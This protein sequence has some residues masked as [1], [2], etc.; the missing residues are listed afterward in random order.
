MENFFDP[1]KRKTNKTFQYLAKYILERVD[2]NP[3]F[4]EDDIM[5]IKDHINFMF[6]NSF[7]RNKYTKKFDYSIDMS[8]P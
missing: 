8:S 1:I 5:I 2:I 4:K 7:F 3:D 6:E